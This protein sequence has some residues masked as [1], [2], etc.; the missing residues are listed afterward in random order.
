MSKK[1][2]VCVVA[3]FLLVTGHLFAAGV[4]NIELSWQE[5][6]AVVRIDVDG[7]VRYTH[8]TE[9]P[10]NGKPDRVII[11]ILAATHELGARNFDRLPDCIVSSIRTSQFAVSPEKIVRVV[12]DL[13]SAPLYRVNSDK[14]AV[15]VYLT[16]R[17]SQSFSPWSSRTSLTAPAKAPSK[18][19]S[20]PKGKEIASA[21]TPAGSA[22]KSVVTAVPKADKQS[23][24]ESGAG[25]KVLGYS[26]NT[27]RPETPAATK[28]TAPKVNKPIKTE[29]KPESSQLAEAP[30]K[31]AKTKS[32]EKT[33]SKAADSGSKKKSSK[34]GQPAL[35]QNKSKTKTTAKKDSPA[36]K[37]TPPAQSKSKSTAR[38]RRSPSDMKAAGTLVAEFPTRLVIK[39]KGG[40]RRDPFETLI[41]VSKTND[42]PIERRIPN[43]E[44]LRLV[45][46][47]ESS[48]EANRAL[49]EDNDGYG[50]ILQ[51]G[52]KVKNG[53]VLRVNANKVFFQIFE[54]GW[55]RTV[56]LSI[57]EDY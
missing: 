48:S 20:T 11:D 15:Y 30:S 56:A 19:D 34:G 37:K 33:V 51:S 32:G 49:F 2:I 10:K 53:Y 27:D 22:Q 3:A 21:P 43:V 25:S 42:N 8:Q 17:T 57:D 54:Y 50:Y 31:D 29:T 24:K 55:S 36:V 44:G 35:A 45:G 6:T 7:Q 1:T 47:I 16:D 52:D 46:I 39:Y 13:K 5:N 4:K 40:N 41:N 23:G 14:N 9:E 12:L 28:P 18:A 26:D 38:F